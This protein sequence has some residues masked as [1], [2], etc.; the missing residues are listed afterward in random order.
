M[1]K[2]NCGVVGVG[3]LGAHHARI[4]SE[5][6]NVRLVGIYDINRQRAEEVAQLYHCPIFDSMEELAEQ[7]DALSVVTPTTYHAATAIPLMKAGCHLLVEKP[8]CVTLEEAK[9]MVKTAEEMKIFLQVGHIENY[10]PVTSYLE[11]QVQSPKYITSDR[12]APF[13][14]RGADVGV[15]LDLM[16]HDLGVVLQLVRSPIQRIEAIGVNVISKTEDIANARIYFE[17]GC[18]ANFNTSR[19]SLKK[20]RNIRIFQPNR[21]LS[22]D[23]MEQKG[24]LMYKTNGE[25]LK[26]EI[27]LHKEEPLRVELSAFVDCVLQS[28][29]P[30]VN[31][32]VARSALSV[33][34]EI[35]HKIQENALV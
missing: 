6:D 10:N 9:T 8:L 21:Y 25:I 11:T 23:Y 18:V 32:Q 31:G 14:P 30:K 7:C 26:E 12:L 22:L 19:V 15:V 17:N 20:E 3:Y 5:M 2:I 29:Q 24:H 28:H 33:A 27:P 13:N 16:I 4:Y 34:I 1:K 35:T